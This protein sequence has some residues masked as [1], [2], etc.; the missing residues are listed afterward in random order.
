MMSDTTNIGPYQYSNEVIGINIQDNPICE[1]INTEECY[2]VDASTSSTDWDI[3]NNLMTPCTFKT[4]LSNAGPGDYVYLKPGRYIDQ[5]SDWERAF[6]PTNSGT[7]D[8]PITFKSLE[9]GQAILV[10]S[11]SGNAAMRVRFKDYIVIDGF[12]TEGSLGLFW[13]NNGIIR[14]NEVTI[15]TPEGDDASLNWGVFLHNSDNSI[16]ENNIIHNLE[17]S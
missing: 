1:A 4:A 14:N 2:Y 13:S 6:S 7:P 17:D 10:K 9:K 3:C 16:V 5:D 15:G 12:K 8:N 11:S